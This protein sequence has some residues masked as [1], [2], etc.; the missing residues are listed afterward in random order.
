[1]R[2]A[3]TGDSRFLQFA[4]ARETARTPWH[5]A[6]AARVRS[7]TLVVVGVVVGRA[8]AL[9]AEGA[10]RPALPRV[11]RR[12]RDAPEH[13]V[14]ATTPGPAWD[15]D[16]APLPRRRRARRAAAVARRAARRRPGRGRR[17]RQRPAR[18]GAA[19]DRLEARRA[20]LARPLARATCPAPATSPDTRSM[21][22][23]SASRSSSASSSS[24]PPLRTGSS[25]ETERSRSSSRCYRATSGGSC[26]TRGT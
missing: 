16:R 21:R 23:C 19:R 12:R 7:A 8:R 22:P 18:R 26:A 5:E 1:M 20:R 3:S 9:E 6:T 15:R 10:D 4:A 25:S 13:R 2:A 11:H 17:R 24:S 14:A